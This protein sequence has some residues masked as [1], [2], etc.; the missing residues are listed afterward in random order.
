MVA[1]IVEGIA[2]GRVLEIGCGLGGFGARLAA[3][4]DYTGV[5]QDETSYATARPR[6]E[7]AGGRAVHGPFTDL[8]GSAYDLVC[9]FEVLEHIEDD[10]AAL[11]DWAK[12]IAP[13]GSLVISVP[14]GPERYGEWDR[15]V[16]HYRRYSPG[17]LESVLSQAGFTGIRLT[18]YGWPLGFATEAI[19]NRVAG[20]RD[21][22]TRA[23]AAMADRTASSG[24]RLQPGRL[25]GPAVRVVVAP[26]LALQ[27]RRPDVG[28][29][30]VAVA[31]KPL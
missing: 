18:H 15:A 4:Y 27:A 23:G 12:L 21:R 28:V 6:I 24:R 19:R 2:P 31:R 29:G 30:M 7:A 26:V 3:R 9:A 5:E 16:G 17:R 14:A 25:A 22:R 11:H 1:P 8:E 10:Q 13:G 20:R